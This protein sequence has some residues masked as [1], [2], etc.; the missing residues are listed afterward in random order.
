M[1]H[2]I[3]RPVTRIPHQ[4]FRAYIL[5]KASCSPPHPPPVRTRS[6]HHYSSRHV[7]CGVSFTPSGQLL[8]ENFASHTKSFSAEL[9]AHNDDDYVGHAWWTLRIRV[10][11]CA[12]VRVCDVCKHATRCSACACDA[13]TLIVLP[14]M[15]PHDYYY[16]KVTLSLCA[17]QRT[18]FRHVHNR[19]WSSSNL[20]TI[21]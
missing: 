13:K 19:N 1:I 18:H 15:R 10:R 12:C 11:L 20:H 16:P 7:V 6:A 21:I 9:R 17:L 8:D 2:F 5:P 3:S 14:P 4:L